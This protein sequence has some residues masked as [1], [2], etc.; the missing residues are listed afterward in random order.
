MVATSYLAVL[1]GLLFDAVLFHQPPSALA[2]LGAGLVCS[3]SFV[4]VL[5]RRRA[6]E[7]QLNSSRRPYAYELAG[8]GK[9]GDAA[10]GAEEVEAAS[11]PPLKPRG[12]L[13]FSVLF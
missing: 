1:W 10:E 13:L 2:L 9:V 4:V 8:T 7:P 12:I 11:T 3:S 5:D 6:A